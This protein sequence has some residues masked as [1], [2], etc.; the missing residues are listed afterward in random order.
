MAGLGTDIFL[1]AI[2]SHQAEIVGIDQP[3]SRKWL[4]LLSD[5]VSTDWRLNS[6]TRGAKTPDIVDY[7]QETNNLSSVCKQSSGTALGGEVLL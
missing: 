7:W 6:I 3:Q 5:G 2:D 1:F 4:K